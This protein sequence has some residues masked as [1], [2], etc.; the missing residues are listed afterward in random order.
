MVIEK[1][2]LVKT[3]RQR[4]HHVLSKI[5]LLCVCLNNFFFIRKSMS[6]YLYVVKLDMP[7]LVQI[8]YRHPEILYTKIIIP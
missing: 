4:K 8:L 6:V 1:Q 7:F 3:K 2:P 5:F